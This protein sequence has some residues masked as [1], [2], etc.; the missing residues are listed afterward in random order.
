MTYKIQA[1]IQV[2]LNG[3]TWYKLTDHNRDPIQIDV[4]LI[5]SSSRMANG[6][7][8]KYVIAKK[9]KIS[10]GWNF[11]PTKTT[12]T[13]DGNYG[14]AW[15]ESFYKANAGVPIYVKVIESKLDVEPSAGSVPSESGHNFKTAATEATVTDATGF[16]T[17]SAYITSFSKTLSKR[18]PVADYV[19]I[20]IEFTEI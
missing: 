1:G 20:K 3:S 18:T 16:R 2:S 17:Y 5:E 15:M 11:I 8:R 10:T 12:E 19:D 6:S 13:A 7:M 9:Y 4:E 14:A